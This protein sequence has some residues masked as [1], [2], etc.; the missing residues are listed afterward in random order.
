MPVGFIASLVLAARME[1]AKQARSYIDQFMSFLWLG[2]VITLLVVLFFMQKLGPANTYPI[3]FALYGLGTFVSGSVL[4]FRPLQIGGVTCWMAAMASGFL[5]HE[6]QIAVGALLMIVAYII[7]G[8][9]LRN[10]FKQQPG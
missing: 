7:P 9:L 3:I 2:F 6:I 1:K 5:P 10:R 8:Y 4:Q